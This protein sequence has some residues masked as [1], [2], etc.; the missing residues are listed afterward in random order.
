MTIA[1][2][3]SGTGSNAVKIIEY[4]QAQ[5]Q[6]KFIVF[7]N[8]KDAPVLE[9]VQHIGVKTWVFGKKDFY[10]SEQVLDLL[11]SEKVDFIVLAGFLWLVPENIIEA[12]PER[13][14]NLHP[15]LLPKYGGKGMFGHHVHQ[16]VIHAKEKESGITIHYANGKYDEGNVIFQAKCEVTTDETP[17]S[18]AKK[19]HILE[20]QYLPPT[21]GKIWEE[22]I[23][24][25]KKD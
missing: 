1:I 23:T 16:A 17:E 7:S 13:I 3:A 15:A 10:E 4:F 5:P 21:L 6:Y 11:K 19:V 18:L 14:V 20:H 8:K 9:K 22:L 2:F 12:Y 25:H 24:R